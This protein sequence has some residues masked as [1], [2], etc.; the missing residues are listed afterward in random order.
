MSISVFMS[1]T[2]HARYFLFSFLT[3]T[4]SLENVKK[5]HITLLIIYS[6]TRLRLV[7]FDVIL[8]N[9]TLFLQILFKIG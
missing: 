9:S 2:L 3:N 7:I 1:L 4:I 6:Q 5:T 8:K